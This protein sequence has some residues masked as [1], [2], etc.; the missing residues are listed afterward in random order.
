MRLSDFDVAGA[1]PVHLT[2]EQIVEFTNALNAILEAKRQHDDPGR[3]DHELQI[4]GAWPL[5]SRPTRRK[6]HIGSSAD[7]HDGGAI[8]PLILIA[9][10]QCAF[11][12]WAS[13]AMT[14]ICP[15]YGR[16]R[17]E[18]LGCPV[19]GGLPRVEV[20]AFPGGRKGHTMAEHCPCRPYRDNDAH[21]L[22][23]HRRIAAA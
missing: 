16:H 22:L 15:K 20:Q 3:I 12:L 6:P 9:A 5:P 18:V 11:L 21:T 13:N 7:P 4:S 1:S 14:C 23:V 2:T 10:I 17:A 8:W 19:H